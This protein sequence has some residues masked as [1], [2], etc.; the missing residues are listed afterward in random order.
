MWVFQL[1]PTALNSKQNSPKIQKAL[2]FK[3]ITESQVLGWQSVGS[4][5]VLPHYFYN[6]LWSVFAKQVQ[7]TQPYL[8]LH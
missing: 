5:A 6:F 2:G 8:C 7:R 3:K 1:Q 4:L